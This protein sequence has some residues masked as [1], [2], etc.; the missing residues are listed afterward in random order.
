MLAISQLIKIVLGIVVV[1]AVVTGLFFFGG[2]V[3]D[4]FN[5]LVSNETSRLYLSII[6]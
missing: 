3:N 4:F 5:N 2:Y 1:V 6:K